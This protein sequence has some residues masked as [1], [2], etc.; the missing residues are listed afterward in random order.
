[1]TLE[2][3]KNSDQII[4]S[5]IVGSHAYGIATP[6]SDTDVK[7]VFMQTLDSILKD[8][9]IEQV[10]DSKND[11][12]YYEL[13]RFLELLS[14]NN[15]TI[16][17]LLNLPMDCILLKDPIFDRILDRK[18]SFITMDC[19]MSF[20]GYAIQQIKKAR[21]LN[22]KIV[23]PMDKKRKSVL[24]FCFVPHNQGSMELEKWLKMN[25]MSQEKCGLVAVP[26]MRYV[27]SMFYDES[28]TLG[29]KGIIKDEE[30][31]NDVSLSSVERDIQPVATV[32][33]NKDGYSSHCKEYR[34]YWDWVKERNQA[35]YSDNMLNGKG[36]DG[37]NMAHC[38]RLLDMAIEIGMGKGINV[39]R[40]NREE[41]LG[42]RKGLFDYD[43]LVARAEEK[44]SEMERVYESSSLPE[45]FDNEM[46]REMLLEMRKERYKLK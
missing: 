23:K 2:Q 34:E 43:Y 41:L 30:E 7:G 14:T 37:K 8:G 17:E 36:F 6:T 18:N 25:G 24:D 38:H 3:L 46:M 15:P 45:K 26:H 16:M 11:T 12:T 13:K 39:R 28:G 4:F 21:G 44:I 33:F 5:G 29:Y 35:R 31:S 32:S 42:I 9:Y 27:Y 19:K 10:S 1:M 22:K 20:G 40:E